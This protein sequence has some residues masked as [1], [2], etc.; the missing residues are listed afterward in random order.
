MFGSTPLMQ[1]SSNYTIIMR[2]EDEVRGGWV[3]EL[4][5][6]GRCLMN[7]PFVHPS[8]HLP[9]MMTDRQIDGWW[10]V[11]LLYGGCCRE[12]NDRSSHATDQWWKDVCRWGHYVRGTR[13]PRYVAMITII[14]MLIIITIIIISIITM[15]IIILSSPYDVKMP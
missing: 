3:V 2:T 5:V 4:L 6:H 7:H 12:L 8:I 11:D 10:M 1:R 15:I 14:M 13:A 9:Y